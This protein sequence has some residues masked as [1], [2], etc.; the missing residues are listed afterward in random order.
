MRC[1]LQCQR[2]DQVKIV[3]EDLYKKGFRYVV[4]DRG[5]EFLTCFSIKPK[6]FRDIESWGY[7]NSSLP[8]ALPAAIIKNEDITEIN[9][10]NISATLIADF[11]KV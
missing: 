2:R 1:I 11:I 6:K 10:T 4:R 8:K 7:N 5:S 9:W 3:L